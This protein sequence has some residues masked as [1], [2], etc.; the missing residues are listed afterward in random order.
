[1]TL[2]FSWS[3]TI[4]KADHTDNLR[5]SLRGATEAAHD[6]LD[7]SMRAAAGWKTRS[8][9]ARFLSLQY[10]ARLPVEAWL[11]ENAP[12]ALRPPAQCPL[13][14]RDLRELGEI[15]PAEG[16]H[17][18][19]PL[20]R[21]GDRRAQILGAA[22]VLAGSSLGNRAILGEVRRMAQANGTAEWP[23]HFLGDE[24]MLDFWKSLRPM[25]E[26]SAEM[27]Q[28]ELAS[29][30]ASAVFDHFIAHVRPETIE[31]G[32]VPVDTHA[33]AHVSEGL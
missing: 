24:V 25:L 16:Q 30:A 21:H 2:D 5:Q 4:G 26:T 1:M 23:T 20:R 12:H 22:W 15:L 7:G 3:A 32:G 28:V 19:L 33:K 6:L 27:E 29:H 18:A 8:D 9:Y 11:S 13:I 31:P 14:A 10:A 17:F